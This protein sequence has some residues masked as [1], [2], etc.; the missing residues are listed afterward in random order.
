MS[1]TPSQPGRT[2]HPMTFKQTV[3]LVAGTVAFV[4]IGAEGGSH[5]STWIPLTW[6]GLG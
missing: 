5:G 4:V 3:A 6:L 1:G 2:D